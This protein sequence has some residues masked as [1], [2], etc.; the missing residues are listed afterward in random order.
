MTSVDLDLVDRLTNPQ[1]RLLVECVRHDRAQRRAIEERPTRIYDALYAG[2]VRR[3]T[4]RGLAE[5]QLVT[6]ECYEGGGADVVPT[7]LG[8]EVARLLPEWQVLPF[9]PNIA[10]NRP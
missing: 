9:G 7:D 10:N 3:R 4:A 1:R 6:A 8:R 5:V 2:G